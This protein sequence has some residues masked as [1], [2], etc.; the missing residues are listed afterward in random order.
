MAYRR[1]ERPSALALACAI[2]VVALALVSAPPPLGPSPAYADEC[3]DLRNAIQQLDR[4]IA[5]M[6]SAGTSG[7]GSGGQVGALQDARR[8]YQNAYDAMNC[9]GGGLN[10]G[11]VRGNSEADSIGFALGVAGF[12]LDMLGAID[13]AGADAAAADARRREAEAMR[14]EAERRRREAERLA[15]EQRAREAADARMRNATANPFGDAAPQSSGNPFAAP[16]VQSGGAPGN[17]VAPNE[18]AVSE[19]IS[20]PVM[21]DL[22]ARGVTGCPSGE[23]LANYCSV[24]PPWW[25]GQVYFRTYSPS[26][27]VTYVQAATLDTPQCTLRYRTDLRRSELEVRRQARE[28]QRQQACAANPF[29]EECQD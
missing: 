19:A 8:N 20:R 13:N 24:K 26:E 9:A 14:A 16:F 12:M 22:H 27:C 17:L 29:A 21:E 23:A 28:L 18:A 7:G 4:E 2:S 10:A 3:S 11:R 5:D 15:A 6:G 1:S 25:D